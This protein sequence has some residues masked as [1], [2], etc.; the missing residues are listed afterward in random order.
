MEFDSETTRMCI[1]VISCHC[2]GIVFKRR[3]G[4]GWV[5]SKRG[6][7]LSEVLDPPLVGPGSGVGEI[8][9]ADRRPLPADWTA[10]RENFMTYKRTSFCDG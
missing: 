6:F 10:N 8:R 2:L 3:W 4:I 7:H 9:S 1:D 5:L